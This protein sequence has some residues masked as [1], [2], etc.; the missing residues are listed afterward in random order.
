MATTSTFAT[1]TP[2]TPAFV[3]DA[4]SA[5]G[6]AARTTVTIQYA[7]AQTAGDLNV[8]GI[9]WND[10]TALVQS[11]TDTRGNVYQLAVGPTVVSGTASLAVYYAANIASSVANGNTVTVTFNR[12]TVYPDVRIAEYRNVATTNPLDVAAGATGTGATANSGN[13]TTTNAND[14][15][16]G[17]NYVQTY[18]GNAGTGFT[19]RR[20]TS[21]GNLLEDRNVT[22]VGSYSAT[23]TQGSGW[24]IMQI[25]AFRAGFGPWSRRLS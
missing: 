7:A 1:G 4:F 22:A 17:F 12:A 13:V 10:A 6:S 20:V 25:V 9:A 8:I 11:V 24:W 16:V 3:Q 19:E 23:S 18:T 2:L 21:D 5:P 14:L 15:L